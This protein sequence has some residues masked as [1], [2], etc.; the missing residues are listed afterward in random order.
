MNSKKGWLLLLT[1]LLAGQSYAQSN[2]N[3]FVADADVFLN[4]Y[5]EKGQVDYAEIKDNFQEIEKLYN[6]VGSMDLSAA[7]DEERK[8]F[9]INAYNLIVIYQVSKY[10]PLKS[11]LDRSGFFDKVDHRI[12]GKEMTLNQ[13]EIGILIR[14]YNDP[15]IHFAL[16]CAAKGCPPL[17]DFAFKPSILDAQLDKRSRKALNDSYFIRVYPEKKRV[18]ISKIFDWYKKDFSANGQE[19]LK[20]I[21]KYRNSK[22]PG[23]YE[24]AFYEYDWSLNA[25]ETEM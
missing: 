24:V 6:Q 20:F 22:I 4:K 5:V 1:I 23:S 15:R 17:A 2:L 13:L 10:Y 8:A 21:N 7:N 18:E 12:A 11:A 14:K 25:M 9:Y 16:A 19:P 3:R